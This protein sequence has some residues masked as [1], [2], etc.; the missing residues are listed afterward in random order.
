MPSDPSAA[1]SC[2][3]FGPTRFWIPSSNGLPTETTPRQAAQ[4]PV[5][6]VAV[7]GRQEPRIEI[8]ADVPKLN[9]WQK[10]IFQG[11]ISFEVGE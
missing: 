2:A 6:A 7:E 11:P 3:I 5:E 10:P 9:R 8:H 1:Y 4:T